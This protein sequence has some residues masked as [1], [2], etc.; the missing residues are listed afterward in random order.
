L[1]PVRSVFFGTEFWPPLSGFV[2]L[3]SW[4]A[5]SGVDFSLICSPNISLHRFTDSCRLLVDPVFSSRVSSFV[6]R[7]LGF[8]FNQ[9]FIFCPCPVS[10]LRFRRESSFATVTSFPRRLIFLPCERWPRIPVPRVGFLQ[11][12]HDRCGSLAQMP[13]PGVWFQVPGFDSPVSVSSCR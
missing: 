11:L 2:L 7:T 10:R 1:E 9:D 12:A 8:V 6:S 4:A 13:T 3:C 5:R